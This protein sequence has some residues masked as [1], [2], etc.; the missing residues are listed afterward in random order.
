MTRTYRIYINYPINDRLS[1]WIINDMKS[2]EFL[3]EGGE[4]IKVLNMNRSHDSAYFDV[5]IYVVDSDTFP[6]SPVEEYYL[7]VSQHIRALIGQ[8]GQQQETLIE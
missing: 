8:E 5:E 7:L 2:E 6:A 1:N 3:A 4:R